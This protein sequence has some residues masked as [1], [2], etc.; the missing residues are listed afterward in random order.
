M[1]RT[2][3]ILAGHGSHISPNTAGLV[4]RYVD[5]LRVMGV[6]DEVTAGFW[7]EQ[8]SFHDVLA[9]VRA[10]RIVVVPV[11]TAQGFYTRT[12]IPAEMALDIHE[13]V[14]YAKTLGEHPAVNEIVRQRVADALAQH[15]LDPQQTTVAVIGHGTTR[16]KHSQAAALEQVESLQRAGIAAQVIPAYLD[17]QPD[18]PSIYARAKYAHIVAVPFF[19]APG[20]HVTIDV[21]NALGLPDG[22]PSVQHEGQTVYYTSPVGTDES[23]CEVILEL[24]YDAGLPRHIRQDGT[25]WGGFP[26]AGWDAFIAA[27]KHEGSL[28]LGE[29]TVSAETVHPIDVEPSALCLDTPQDLRQHVRENP[30]RPLSSAQGIP[31]DWVTPVAS[32][33]EMCAVVETVYPGVIVDWAANQ[34]GTLTV[35]SLPS[36]TKRLVGSLQQLTHLDSETITRG[37][38]RVCGRCTRHPSWYSDADTQALPCREACHIW[39][40]D[41]MKAMEKQA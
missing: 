40:K 2:A 7:K 14:H 23:M 4:W 24:A 36:L 26:T 34:R 13:N 8:P 16:T 37:V 35:T 18:I 27:V 11:F 22:E 38:A 30:F 9:T 41:A 31:R 19:L 1:T 21:P 5:R 15:Q 28:T 25:V 32:A 17:T 20:S 10:D 29:L 6:A 33:Y 12:V 3:L 39:M